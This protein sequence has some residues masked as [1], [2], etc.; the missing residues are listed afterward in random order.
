LIAE[1]PALDATSLAALIARREVSAAEVLRT[2]ISRIE[3]MN[4]ELNAVAQTFFDRASSRPAAPGPF[5]GVPFLVKDNV[6]ELEGTEI[7]AV[8]GWFGGAKSTGSAT[9]AQRHEAAGLV[10]LGKTTIPE[11]SL[12]FT[13]EPAGFMA[14]RNPWDA[15]R[16]PGGSSGGSAAAVA[17]GLVPMAHGTDG[18]GSIRVPAAHCGLVGFK[19]SR[20]RTPFGPDI[21]EGLG[22]MA[23]AHAL[24]RSVRDSAT[25]LDATHGPEAGDPYAVPAPAKSYLETLQADPPALRIALATASPLGNP[26]NREIEAAVEEVGRLC[27]SLGHHVERAAPVYEIEALAAAWRLIAGVTALGTVR[28]ATRLTGQDTMAALEPVNAAWL[29]EAAAATAPDYAAA[30][31]TVH[32]MGRRLG[33]FFQ[34]YDVLLTP[35][36]AG[37]APKLGELAGAG[38]SVDEFNR[39]FWEH[40]PFTCV[41]NA[42]GGPAVSLPLAVA[43]AGLPIGVH[44]G[45]DFGQDGLLFALAGQLE[46]ARPWA[47]RRPI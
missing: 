38:L 16:S 46:R 20:I 31:Q 17:A 33:A 26:V 7:S 6:L 21:A 42:S 40:A 3:A 36:T 28:R 4:P 24:T 23:Y 15:S 29:A 27:E 10:T 47:A 25:L 2:A 8:H 41:F 34:T 9:L 14:A 45:A 43:Q 32:R 13:S 39:R 30:I 37:L 19:P 22:G 44:F 11:L 1:Y 5:T 12:S 35:V 18:A